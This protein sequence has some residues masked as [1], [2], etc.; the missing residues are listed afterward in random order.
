MHRGKWSASH[1]GTEDVNPTHKKLM[2]AINRKDFRVMADMYIGV[3]QN[4]VMHAELFTDI[5]GSMGM[6]DYVM[7]KCD[8]NKDDLRAIISM[9]LHIEEL[10][11]GSNRF[12][13][14]DN[15]TVEIW[16]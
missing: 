16:V 15:L 3:Y 12:I 13:T 7:K 1:G 11:K 2:D 4:I 8:I 14:S 6:H 9:F 5:K 10:E